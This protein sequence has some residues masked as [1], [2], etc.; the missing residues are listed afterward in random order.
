MKLSVSS[1]CGWNSYQALFPKSS[2][3]FYVRMPFNGCFPTANK[4]TVPSCQYSKR[5]SNSRAKYKNIQNTTVLRLWNAICFM[6]KFF[7]LKKKIMVTQKH[8]LDLIVM[9]TVMIPERLKKLTFSSIAGQACFFF[10]W[11]LCEQFNI[12]F[13]SQMKQHCLTIFGLKNNPTC[14]WSKVECAQVQ[15]KK[16]QKHH[17]NLYTLISVCIIS[18]QFFH[19]ISWGLQQGEFV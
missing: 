11:V 8:K 10:M 16:I 7:L 9:G 2:S 19:Y 13:S 18:I 4:M 17:L 6:V 5:Q 3:F 15:E 12:W 14:T 1:N